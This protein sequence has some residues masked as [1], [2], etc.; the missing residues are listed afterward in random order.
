[1]QALVTLP[2]ICVFISLKKMNFFLRCCAE[3]TNKL[4]LYQYISEGCV[5]LKV[6]SILRTVLPEKLAESLKSVLP[7][8]AVIFLLCFFVAPVPSSV[9]LAFVLGACSL[10]V[11]MGLFSLGAD[12]AMSR[13]GEH[14]GSVMSRSRKLW[15]IL[16]VSFAVGI[17]ITV[18]EPDLMVLAQQVP[19]IPNPV[20]IWSV[21]LGVGLFLVL[22]MLRIFLNISLRWLLVGFYGAL[23][24]LSFFV[25]RDYLSTAFDSGGVTTGPMTVP[26]IMALGVGVSSVRSDRRAG[27]DSFGLIALCSVGPVIAVLLLGLLYRTEGGAYSPFVV[28]E[29]SNSME[30]WK[31]YA[32]AFPHY[33]KEVAMAFL[34]IAGIF[35]VFQLPKSRMRGNELVRALVGILYTYLGLVLFLTGA[36]VGFM[37]VGNYLGELIGILPYRWII[38]PI[39]MLLGYF[40]VAAEPAVHVL[41]KQV[42]DMTE[43]AIPQ[44]AMSLSLSIGVAISVGL[45]MTRV[46]TGLPIMW[47]LGPGYAAALILS[48]FVPPMFTAIAFDSGGVA[49]GP[50]AATFLLPLAMGLCVAVGGNVAQDAFGVVSMVAMI[51]LI[52]IQVL[53]LVYKHKAKQA[54]KAVQ[55]IEQAEDIETGEEIIIV[56]EG[57]EE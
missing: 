14:I 36:N 44:K 18:S 57:G 17:F 2:S 13:I 48:F 47:I 29:I 3:G 34:P 42:A 19:N 45:A 49:S 40:I 51:P 41:N 16:I 9:M 5:F 32:D 4:R 56:F 10:I 26:F 12:M 28:P 22:A 30:L 11:G 37:P 35:A 6:R 25:P 38:V 46:L 23:F 50:M 39:G 52:T 54:A 21:A 20:I 1:M 8:T 53:G 27:E 43:G 24:I 33:F 15:L 7:V 31:L 55:P